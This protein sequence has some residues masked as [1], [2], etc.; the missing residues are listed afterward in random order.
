MRFDFGGTST[1][2]EVFLAP[3]MYGTSGTCIGCHAIS[4]DGTK[5]A[6]SAGGQNSGLLEYMPSPTKTTT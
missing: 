6:A 5:M 4:P 1:T 3:G 2:P